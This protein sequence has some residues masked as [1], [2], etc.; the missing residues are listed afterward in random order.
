MTTLATTPIT[1][2]FRFIEGGRQTKRFKSLKG[3]RKAAQHQIGAH[4]SISERCGYAV[5]DFGCC[6]IS[7]VEGCTLAELFP[8]EG[9]AA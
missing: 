7:V 8:S 5:D 6:T 4:P 3:A 9:G 1:L 2:R